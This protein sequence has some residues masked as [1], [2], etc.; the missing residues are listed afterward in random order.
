MNK[1]LIC[2]GETTDASQYHPN[3]LKK[4]FGSREKP[5]LDIR[6][7][8][9]LEL[10]NKT[11]RQHKSVPGVHSRLLL[12][13]EKASGAD[14]L[15]AIGARG[16]F[17]LIPPSEKWPQLPENRHCTMR[18]AG[19]AGIETV[20][21]GLIPLASGERAS[22]T[23]RADRDD[24]GRK[25]AMEDMCQ[26]AGRLTED[27]YKGSHEQ[28]AKIVRKYSENPLYDL[29]RYF[30]LVLFCYLTGN[31][32]MHMKNFSLLRDPLTGWKLAPASD[33]FSTRLLKSAEKEPEELA[34]TLTEKKSNF[35]RDS[36][37]EFGQKIGLERKQVTTLID[38]LVSKRDQFIEIIDN[39]FLSH[40]KKELYGSILSGR[41][42]NL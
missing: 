21:F 22:I 35:S 16:R 20:P 24:N 18:M 14:K 42:S 5:E 11:V 39:S 3:C 17:I 36:F 19:S 10:A 38:N 28:I 23:R 9:F 15:T 4:L 27:K 12:D 30:D 1:C 37:M 6:L 31:G 41:I 8:Q 13:I 25:Y 2:T 40:W 32:D 33:M 34:L 29:T 26:L 7:D